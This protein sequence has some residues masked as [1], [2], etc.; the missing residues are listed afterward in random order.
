VQVLGTYTISQPDHRPIAAAVKAHEPER[1]EQLMLEHLRA[2]KAA[3]VKDM[4]EI[5]RMYRRAQ[6]AAEN[7]LDRLGSTGAPRMSSTKSRGFTLVEL[8]VVIAIIT[9]LISLLLPALGAGRERANAVVCASTLRQAATA[10][11]SY[12]GDTK[13]YLPYVGII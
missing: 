7:A 13:G 5:D 1:A 6:A 10:T 3:I 9:L 4:T 2:A 8:L 11:I 12:A